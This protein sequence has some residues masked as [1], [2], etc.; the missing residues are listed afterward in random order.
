[1][2]STHGNLPPGVTNSMIES[3]AG[4]E[5]PCPCCGRA[6]DACVCPECEVCGAQGDFRCYESAVK[7]VAGDVAVRR[8]SLLRSGL[9]K[10][11]PLRYTRQQKIGQILA[12]MDNV[13]ERLRDDRAGLE[14]LAF[15]DPE[16]EGY[17]GDEAAADI[18]AEMDQ[19]YRRWLCRQHASRWSKDSAAYRRFEETRSMRRKSDDE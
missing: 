5:G 11:E 14:E 8:C 17:V 3:A 13:E 4:G 18:L 15:E 6:L 10:L 19:T 7:A 9:P 1:M 16:C 12:M 2:K